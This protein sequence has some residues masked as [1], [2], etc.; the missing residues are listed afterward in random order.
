MHKACPVQSLFWY[1][2]L[3]VIFSWHLLISYQLTF[4]PYQ[5]RPYTPQPKPPM[6]KGE[7]GAL[8]WST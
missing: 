5:Q 7:C 6:V 8:R 3:S 1:R 4:Q 2:S